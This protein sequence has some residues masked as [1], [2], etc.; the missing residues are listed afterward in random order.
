MGHEKSQGLRFQHPPQSLYREGNAVLP[1]YPP[2]N[3]LAGG[4][5]QFL[6]HLAET[7]I[8]KE[9]REG[10]QAPW[11]QAVQDP[12]GALETGVCLLAT[13]IL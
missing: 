4:E 5:L 1:Q 6:A 12:D 2:T 10:T 8:Q 9:K 11:I 3:F 7:E 13:C